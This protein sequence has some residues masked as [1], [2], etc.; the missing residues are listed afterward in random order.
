MNAIATIRPAACR[1]LVGLLLTVAPPARAQDA[2][3]TAPATAAPVPP[4][5]SASSAAAPLPQPAVVIP[6]ELQPYRVQIGVAFQSHPRFGSAQRA[7]LLAEISRQV[8]TRIGPLWRADITEV[9][10]LPGRADAL[11]QL[12]PRGLDDCY[13]SSEFDKALLGTV[14]ETDAGVRV[15]CREWDKSSQTATAAVRRDVRDPRLLADLL[16]AELASHFRPIA[17]V[18]ELLPDKSLELRLRGGELLPS[19]PAAAP[20]AAGMYF[21]PYARH[22]DRQH[23]LR[24]VQSIPWT[25]LRLTGVERARVRGETVSAY[26]APISGSKRRVEFLAIAVKP[27]F[28]DT[29]V[30]VF[31]RGQADNPLA[32]TRIELLNRQPS[33]ADPVDDRLT[34]LTDRLGT[35]RIPVDPREPLRLMYVMSGRAVLAVVPFI[36]GETPRLSL[37]VPDDA[38]RLAAEGEMAIIEAE[39]IESVARRE[40]LMARGLGLAKQNKWPEVDQVLAQIDSLPGPQAFT[41]RIERVQLDMVAR[42]R[43]AGDKVQEQRIVNLCRQARGHVERHLTG[44]RLRDFRI[45]INDLR[46]VSART[47]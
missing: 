37:E 12:S 6:F 41:T 17:Q 42:A 23:N 31:P 40:V 5:A 25:Y 19:D 13:L 7:A 14:E 11:E 43:Q 10:W 44:D 4:T 1:L 45:E 8:E 47:P 21:A 36:P 46:S 32:G 34:L 39:L 35:V 27:R 22:F 30:V 24:G 18:D 20:V 38:P 28:Q 9:E 26:P 2:A 33:A 29:A 16:F 15:C 3:T